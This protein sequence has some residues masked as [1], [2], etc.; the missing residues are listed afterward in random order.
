MISISTLRRGRSQGGERSQLRNFGCGDRSACDFAFTICSIEFLEI[1]IDSALDG[2]N[3]FCQSVFREILL[4]C[5]HH[6]IG[7]APGRVFV[8]GRNV[9]LRDH[10][11]QLPVF[12]ANSVLLDGPP[13]SA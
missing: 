3:P 13:T 1:S 2:C 7:T 5:G 8:A 9:I 6:S 4:A 11:G 10:S 12:G